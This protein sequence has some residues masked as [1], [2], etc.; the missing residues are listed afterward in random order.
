MQKVAARVGPDRTFENNCGVNDLMPN[1]GTYP[2]WSPYKGEAIQ[3][4]ITYRQDNTFS[5]NLYRGPWRFMPFE[6]GSK[7]RRVES[8]SLPPRCR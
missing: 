3:K 6:Q 8:G 7:V 1:F 2:A 4:A 5:D